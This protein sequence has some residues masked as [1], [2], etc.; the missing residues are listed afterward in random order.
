MPG[1]NVLPMYLIALSPSATKLLKRVKFPKVLLQNVVRDTKP[2]WE[3]RDF[4]G[5]IIFLDFRTPR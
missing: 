4:S 1:D 3:S 2:M 5:K